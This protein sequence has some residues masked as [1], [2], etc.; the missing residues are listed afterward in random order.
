MSYKQ[1]FEVLFNY[2]WHITNQLMDLAAKLDE[3]DFFDKPEDDSGSIHEKLL[4]N[5]RADNAWRQSLIAGSQ[6][7]PLSR[8]EFSN[9][10]EL[11]AGFESEKIS[12]KEMMDS[13]S[14]D[15]LSE[16]VTLTRSDG[17]EHNFILWRVLQ[18]L[19]LHGMQH[20]AEIAQMLTN[21][22]QSPGNLDF[23]FFSD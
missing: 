13:W 10:D 9:I 5:L 23:I 22:G 11:R 18:H 1:K 21:F 4:H 8:K 17:T 20:H 15:E 2:H 19:V 12:W 16:S 3:S 14:E 7:R 6:Q